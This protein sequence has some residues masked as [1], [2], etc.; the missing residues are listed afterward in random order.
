M[1]VFN[2]YSQ[3]EFHNDEFILSMNALSKKVTEQVTFLRTI[4]ILW[5]IFK[6]K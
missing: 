3:Y 2:N 4:G 5:F 1:G 6:K